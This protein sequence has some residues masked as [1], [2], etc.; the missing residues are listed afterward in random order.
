M[1]NL[2]YF[3]SVSKTG[4]LNIPN[5]KRL[6]ADLLSFAGCTVKLTIKKKNRR[7]SPQNRYLFG[8]VY[9][10]VEIRM[11]ELG[12]DVNTDLVHLFFKD[13]YLQIP[14]IG[15]GGEIIGTLPG[16]T[17]ALNKDE[18]SLYLDKIIK[19]SAETL[20]I[21]IPLPNTELKLF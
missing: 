16:S 21:S 15:D 2:Q 18:F 6:Q 11:N 5:R 3:G 7:S 4:I 12:N 19:F 8:V 20:G 10:E 14:L 9:K 1:K 13:K 17:A